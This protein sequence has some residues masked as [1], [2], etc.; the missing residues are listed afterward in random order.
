MQGE[1]RY[2]QMDR[3]AEMRESLARLIQ[4]RGRDEIDERSKTLQ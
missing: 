2:V 1:M 4:H 3:Q